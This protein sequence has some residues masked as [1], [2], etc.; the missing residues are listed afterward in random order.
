MDAATAL[1]FSFA[2]IAAFVLGIIVHKYAISEAQAV[3]K[4][5][6]D[7][8]AAWRVDVAKLLTKI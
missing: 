1:L 8:I 5:V 4:H 3:K 7:E 6:S 2:V